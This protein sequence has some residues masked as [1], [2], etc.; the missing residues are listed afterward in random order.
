MQRDAL[1]AHEEHAARGAGRG[2]RVDRP[3]QRLHPR[4]GG[5]PD[6]RK[7]QFN[8]AWQAHR[9][10]GSAM[11]PFALVAAVEEGADPATTYYDSQPLHI[12]LG[13]ARCRRTGT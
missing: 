4:H 2:A 12:Y 5:Q 13:R 6:Y 10:L 7:T 9:Q 8:L 1:E 3:G 11:K